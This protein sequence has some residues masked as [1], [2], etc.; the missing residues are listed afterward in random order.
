MNARWY[1]IWLVANALGAAPKFPQPFLYRFLWQQAQITGD[2]NVRH[3]VLVTAINMV[4]TT[5]VGRP[6]RHQTGKHETR[7]S[8]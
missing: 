6:A 8:T 7:R 3:G 4:D 2:T 5:N 1:A